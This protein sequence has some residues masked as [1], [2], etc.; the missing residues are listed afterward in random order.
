LAQSQTDDLDA[1]YLHVTGLRSSPAPKPT[2]IWSPKGFRELMRTLETERPE[3][4]STAAIRLQQ[5]DGDV[6]KQLGSMLSGLARR[7]RL[8]RRLTNASRISQDDTV[9]TSGVTGLAVPSDWTR[10]ATAMG[11]KELVTARKYVQQASSWTG[12]A[13]RSNRPTQLVS[14]LQLDDP[15]IEDRDAADVARKMRIFRAE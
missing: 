2:Q 11:L 8:E 5:F 13:V 7:S 10:D 15:W 1:Y 3:G 6:R 9:G 4:W 14:L 12:L